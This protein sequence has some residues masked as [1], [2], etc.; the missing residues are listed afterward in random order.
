MWPR[1][2]EDLTSYWCGVH[3]FTRVCVPFKN[4]PMVMHEMMTMALTNAMEILN[5][6]DFDGNL[7]N[8]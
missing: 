7:G 6:C 2:V 1:V 5:L 8:R 3:H 4:T